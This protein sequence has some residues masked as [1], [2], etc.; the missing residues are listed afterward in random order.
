MG[1]IPIPFTHDLCN[2]QVEVIIIPASKR[3]S[4][5]E[6]LMEFFEQTSDAALSGSSTE[7]SWGKPVGKEVW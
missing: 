6:R 7:I 4:T 3:R 5:K 1:T 2:K